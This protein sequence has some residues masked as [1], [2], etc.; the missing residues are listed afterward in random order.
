[1]EMEDWEMDAEN[2]GALFVPPLTTTTTTKEEKSVVIEEKT[3]PVVPLEEVQQEMYEPN[4]YYNHVLYPKI[5]HLLKK[6]KKNQYS[7]AYIATICLKNTPLREPEIVQMVL[8][9]RGFLMD[10]ILCWNKINKKHSMDELMDYRNWKIKKNKHGL[11]GVAKTSFNP[12]NT[13]YYM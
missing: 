9:K 3:T 11:V 10:G 5:E 13:A 4:T 7:G 1:M 12:Q 8:Q 2:M 6:Q